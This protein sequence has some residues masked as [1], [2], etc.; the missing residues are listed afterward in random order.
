MLE[1]SGTQTIQAYFRWLRDVDRLYFMY[2]FRWRWWLVDWYRHRYWFS[3]HSLN[4]RCSGTGIS[5]YPD[6]RCRPHTSCHAA[7]YAAGHSHTTSWHHMRRKLW[8][9]THSHAC[10]STPR[11]ELL[12]KLTSAWRGSST[13]YPSATS[14]LAF[15]VGERVLFY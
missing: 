10:I 4:H 9:G 5:D 15:S 11:Q 3:N 1:H 6:G 7:G 13:A 8:R 2:D 12:R 14:C